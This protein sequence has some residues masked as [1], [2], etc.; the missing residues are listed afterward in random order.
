MFNHF[1]K[2]IVLS[3]VIL[4]FVSGCGPLSNSSSESGEKVEIEFWHAMSGNL[5]GSLEKITDDFNKKHDNIHVKL[6]FLKDYPTITNKLQLA[7]QSKDVPALVQLEDPTLQTFASSG[8]LQSLNEMIQKEDLNTGDYVD[9]FM[10]SASHD[11]K[12]Y[13]LPLNRS[14]PILYYNKDVFKKAGI[15]PDQINSWKGVRE[16]SNELVDKGA[17]QYGFEP[18]KYPWF[19]TGLARSNGAELSNDPEQIKLDSPE[20]AE[21]LQL[22]GDMIH[23]DKVS[24]VHYGGEGWAYWYDT[25]ADVTEGKAAMVTGSTADMG[26]MDGEKIGAKPMPTFKG[27]ELSVPTGGTSGVI[28]KNASEEQ[29]QAAFEF[30]KYFSEPDVT[31]Q[32][33]KETGYLPVRHS[34]IEKMESFFEKNPNFKVAVEELKHA[35]PTPLFPSWNEIENEAISK[36]FDQVFVDNVPAEEALKNAQ[37]KAEKILN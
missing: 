33:A 31:E 3:L 25:I 18:I 13:G 5:G 17:V 28:P 32:W 10:K 1:R 16:V 11:G 34:A 27:E 24:K 21:A 2:F 37:K 26:S 15:N 19:F 23:K 6:V 36:A 4:L 20:A 29:Q 35:K 22:W 30:I 7:L 14:V 9:S 12:F 8:H